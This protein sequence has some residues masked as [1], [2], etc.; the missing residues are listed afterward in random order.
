MP[1]VSEQDQRRIADAIGKAEAATTG[2]IVAVIAAESGS[3]LHV[4]FLWASLAALAVPLPLIF[5]TWWPIQTIYV[6]QLLTFVG[7][8]TLLMQRPL[9]Y[10]LA[11]WAL[12]QVRAHKRALEQFM[13]QNL[14]T[15][16]NHTGVLIFVSVAERYAEIIADKGIHE[17]VAE[18][19]WDRIVADLTRAIGEGRAGDGLVVAITEVGTHLAQHFPPGTRRERGLPNHLILLPGA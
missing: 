12:K 11:P 2:E 6:L 9:R 16:D 4:P 18:G 3:Y 17:R 15:T 14:H 7:L 10:R 1:L 8:V 13:A 5:W 19:T